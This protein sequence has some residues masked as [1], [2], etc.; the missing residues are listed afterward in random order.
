MRSTNNRTKQ[1]FHRKV[2]LFCLAF[3]EPVIS[4]LVQA[5]KQEPGMEDGK[6]LY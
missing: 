4:C 1:N 3:L 5:E 6:A 2:P